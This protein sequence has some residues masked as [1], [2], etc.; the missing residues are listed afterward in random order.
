MAK[1]KTPKRSFNFRIFMSSFLFLVRW[2]PFRLTLFL[3]VSLIVYL[4]LTEEQQL[5]RTHLLK[6]KLHQLV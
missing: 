2:R 6:W 3:Q 1:E 4:V 5:I